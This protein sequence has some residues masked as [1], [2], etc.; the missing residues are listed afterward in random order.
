MFSN[1]AWKV[2]FDPTRHGKLAFESSDCQI[3]TTI[4][5]YEASWKMIFWLVMLREITL[6]C[7]NLCKIEKGSL[8]THFDPKNTHISGCKIVHLCTIA[9]VTV[10]ICTVTIALLFIILYFFSLLYHLIISP[11]SFDLSLPLPS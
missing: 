7:V 5:T 9:T 6:D 3:Q 1:E 11:L 8:F 2:F 10:H 4:T